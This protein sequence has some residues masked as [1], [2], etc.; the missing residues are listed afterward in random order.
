MLLFLS[1]MTDG[2]HTFIEQ[3]YGTY[4]NKVYTIAL[5]ILKN[6]EDAEDSV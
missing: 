5:A 6:R 4:K 2:E 3:L 1:I